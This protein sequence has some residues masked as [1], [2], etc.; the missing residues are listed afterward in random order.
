M[1]TRHC[2]GRAST[3]S[4]R[5]VSWASPSFAPST[6][7][8]AL[9]S[10]QA[11]NARARRSATTG[12]PT[13]APAACSTRSRS[14]GARESRARGAAGR[15]RRS[16]QQAAER[17]FAPPVSASETLRTT[18]TRRRLKA[19]RSGD[20]RTFEDSWGQVGGGAKAPPSSCREVL[21]LAAAVELPEL[22]VAADRAAVDDDLGHSPPAGE[23]EQAPPEVRVVVQ[24]DLLERDPARLQ[25][26]LRADAVPAPAGRVHLDPGH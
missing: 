5:P 13:A 23:V 11:S 22:G 4:S 6:V 10:R 8:S 26:R 12:R 24:R 18:G 17:G 15:S 1:P 3:R 9:R 25:Q 14:T 16:A 7:A 20:S 21:E 2:G 19:G